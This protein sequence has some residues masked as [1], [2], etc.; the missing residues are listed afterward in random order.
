MEYAEWEPSPRLAP[1][2]RRI[3]TLRGAAPT[4]FAPEP[5]VP[6]GCVELIFHLGDPFAQVVDN[7]RS[8]QP[9]ALVVGQA[10]APA[11]VGPTGAVNV[12]GIRL[13]P[14]SAA[15]LL[16][17]S[18][19]VLRDRV[20]SM[21]ELIGPAANRL[22]NRLGELSSQQMS[23]ENIE[24]LIESV[25]VKRVPPD[26]AAAALVRYF[27]SQPT[28]PSTRL[29]ANNFGR[30]TRWVQRTFAD[31]I[32]LAP[33]MLVRIVRVQRVLGMVR[34]NPSASWS[35]VALEAGYY[36]QSHLI[37]DFRQLVGA[38]PTMLDLQSRSLTETFVSS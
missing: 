17:V 38:P 7:L 12:V 34:D 1:F 15:S 36:D 9:R 31:A 33:K 13:H 11:I 6:D 37:R 25:F 5:I 22:W 30:T 16:D 18:A 3:W 20:F 4:V 26:P 21:D 19:A 28:L 23:R 2:V 32:G 24:R 14:W 10:T 35:N 27:S 29:A 8:M